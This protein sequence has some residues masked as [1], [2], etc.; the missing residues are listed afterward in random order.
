M[1]KGTGSGPG[2]ITLASTVASGLLIFSL[3][4]GVRMLEKGDIGSACFW[5]GVGMVPVAGAALFWV[6][7][8]D[9]PVWPQRI[10]LLVVG[11]ILGGSLS[12][13]VGEFV[14]PVKAQSQQAG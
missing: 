10:I 12:N 9:Q 5:C 3:T 14:R 1:N 13:G 7:M 2:I 8:G 6:S 11:A 4:Q